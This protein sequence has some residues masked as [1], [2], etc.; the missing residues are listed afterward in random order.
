MKKIFSLLL[1]AVAVCGFTLGC[2]GGDSAPAPATPP[3]S[4]ETDAGA[5]AAPAEDEAPAEGE[6]PAEGEAAPEAPA[7]S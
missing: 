5:A 1:I 4:E 6:K 2:A 3:S 7:E